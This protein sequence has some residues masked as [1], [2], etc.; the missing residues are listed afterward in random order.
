MFSKTLYILCLQCGFVGGIGALVYCIR[1]FYI[2][3]AVKGTPLS[4]MKPWISWYLLRPI[5]GTMA[6]ST[7]ML[8]TLSFLSIFI[9]DATK[10]LNRYPIL[11]LAFFAGYN[12]DNFFKRIEGVIQCIFGIKKSNASKKNK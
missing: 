8:I 5:V 1:A 4:A 12:I 9:N 11:A 3:L 10:D 6:G 2:N 7:S